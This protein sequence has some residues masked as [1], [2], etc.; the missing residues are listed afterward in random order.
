MAVSF[1]TA[2]L[3]HVLIDYAFGAAIL[4]AHGNLDGTLIVHAFDG[5]IAIVQGERN[6]ELYRWLGAIRHWCRD[7]PWQWPL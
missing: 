1:Q 4:I 3:G 6:P 2:S 5:N 7:R